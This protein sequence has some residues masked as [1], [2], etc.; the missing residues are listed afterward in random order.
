MIKIK[1]LADIPEESRQNYC[2][3]CNADTADNSVH[4]SFY[5]HEHFFWTSVTLCDKCRRELHE[6][7]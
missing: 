2:D 3:G 5:R 1:Y 4:I 6:R 7:I